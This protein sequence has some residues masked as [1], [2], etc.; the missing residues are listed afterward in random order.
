MTA[1]P[2][3]AGE[4]YSIGWP[5]GYPKNTAD[6]LTITPPKPGHRSVAELAA[7]A[8]KKAG[9]RIGNGI[10]GHPLTHPGTPTR[11]PHKSV[12]QPGNADKI[13]LW[14]TKGSA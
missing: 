12:I 13:G 3:Q 7:A 5:L 2:F 11:A 10:D 9:P 14:P 1:R 4:R 8:K 6:D